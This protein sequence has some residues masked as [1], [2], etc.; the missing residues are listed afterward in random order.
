MD[1]AQAPADSRQYI[2]A[3]L[4]SSPKDIPADFRIPQADGLQTGLF[5][6]RDDPDW[7]GRSAYPPRILL[8]FPRMLAVIAH[9]AAQER[10]KWIGLNEFVFVESGHILLQGWLRLVEE[11][12]ET[13]LQF[14]TR[15]RHV[16]EPFLDSFLCEVLRGTNRFPARDSR[17]FGQPLNL[18]FQN[19]QAGELNA[20]EHV[21]LRFFSP[22]LRTTIRHGLF[23]RQKWIP[24]DLVAITNQRALWITDNCEGRHEPYGTIA[25]SAP[26][27]R[28]KMLFC[29]NPD[30]SAEI[31]C[32]FAAEKEWRIVI[33]LE[34]SADAAR[35]VEEANRDLR[36][37][38]LLSASMRQ[39]V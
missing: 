15:S 33:P 3:Y 39:R 35:F 20:E 25:R 29:D 1:K 22:A 5:L 21:V 14:N 12:S 36:N 13:N 4:I 27:N 9:P 30:D 26:L 32:T 18:K 2:F 31:R 37:A 38:G 7:F 24:G 28:L 8:L 19:A 23:R 10:E 16:I 6:P 34:M 17:W 11:L